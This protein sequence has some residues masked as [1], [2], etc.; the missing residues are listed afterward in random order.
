MNAR[1]LAVLA[2]AIAVLT[3]SPA[4]AQVAPANALQEWGLAGSWSGRCDRPP[5]LGNEYY[6]FVVE[7]DGRAFLQ[8]DFGDPGRN[9]R[10]EIVSAEQRDDG[11]LA[12]RINFAAFNQVRLNAYQKFEG[13]VRVVH[14]AGPGGDVT[15]ENG[16]LRHN[17]QPTPWLSK[18][19]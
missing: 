8:R 19:G 10:S 14:N 1:P 15:V 13:R 16:A 6:R 17:G 7:A 11:T 2:V 4:A 3:A 5:S 9:D 18:C 12:L